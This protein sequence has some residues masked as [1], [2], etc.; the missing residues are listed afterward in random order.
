MS[1]DYKRLPSTRWLKTST[2]HCLTGLEDTTPK[3]RCWQDHAASEDPRGESSSPLPSIWCWSAILGTL[4]PI[5]TSFWFL[6]HSNSLLLSVSSNISVLT[7]TSAIGFGAHTILHDLILTWLH[8]QRP[9]FQLRS[10][11]QIQ[12]AWSWVYFG[13]N[14]IYPLTGLTWILEKGSS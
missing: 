4:W 9:Y 12:R 14:T 1:Q 11:S 6:P 13:R 3:S 7:R 2:M 10:H 5:A 8:L